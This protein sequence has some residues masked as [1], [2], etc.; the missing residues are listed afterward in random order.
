MTS[1]FTAHTSEL[2]PRPTHDISFPVALW[3]A[4]RVIAW[5]HLYKWI[6]LPAN[7]LPTFLFPLVFFMSF[8]GALQE[9]RRIPGF[10]YPAGYTSFIF[11]FSIIQTCMF[12]GMA[13]GFT[14][15]G[16]F[17]SGFAR[18]VFV[19]VRSRSAILL[20]YLFSTFVR[21]ALMC[22]IVTLIAAV[23]GMK[24]LGSPAEMLALYAMA[25][26]LSFVGTLWSSGVMFRGRSPQFAPA[27]QVPMFVGLFLS[28]V[29]VPYE[30]L[31]GWIK[32]V[33][34]FNPVTYVM[35]AMRGFLAGYPDHRMTAVLC[36]AGLIVVLAAWSLSGLRSAE[37]AG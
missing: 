8:S 10:D 37:R 13:T 24:M 36:I 4:S 30:L 22:V 29:Y 27:M 31:R 32:T 5:R 3:R 9:V 35:E 2:A 25:L 18:R 21:A 26:S 23:V 6:K 14:I 33:A 12:G 34:T 7:F 19:C 16:D 17:Q 1:S 11:V 28:P 15:A 20:G